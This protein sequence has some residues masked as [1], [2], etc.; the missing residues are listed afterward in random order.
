MTDI[1]RRPGSEQPSSER[2]ERP[3]GEA[4]EAKGAA[5]AESRAEAS[6][7]AAKAETAGERREAKE[8][9]ADI[10]WERPKQFV[11][12]VVAR[13]L[14]PYFRRFLGKFSQLDDEAMASDALKRTR[15][16]AAKAAGDGDSPDKK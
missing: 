6:D 9:I 16:E 7:R 3:R 4:G 2:G 11:E 15:D 13:K 8:R 12:R 10:L 14:G 1:E 5:T